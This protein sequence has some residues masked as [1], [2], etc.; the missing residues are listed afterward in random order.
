[1]PELL[2]P[3]KRFGNRSGKASNPGKAHR[4]KKAQPKKVEA[5]TH[6]HGGEFKE[7]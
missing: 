3:A 2:P 1:M 5:I 4:G 7:T 6:K